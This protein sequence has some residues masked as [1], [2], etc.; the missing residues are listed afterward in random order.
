MQLYTDDINYAADIFTLEK[1][2]R[3]ADIRHLLPDLQPLA[4]K[5]FTRTPLLISRATATGRWKHGFVVKESS[6]SHY[7]LLI[8]L[9]QSGTPLPDGIV[10]LAGSGRNFHGQRGRPWSALEGNIHLA[11][12]FS[13][14][15]GID[16]Y[17]IGFPIVSAV[18]IVEAIDRIA[19]LKGRADIKWVNDVLIDGAKVA[20]FLAYTSSIGDCVSD[21]V[22][23]IGLNVEASP[24]VLPDAFVPGAASL[25]DF[26]PCDKKPVLQ[27]LLERLNH[28]YKLLLQGRCP[29][30]LD[31][32]RGRS[33]IIGRKVRILSDPLEG[34][35]QWEEIAAGRVER[36]GDH[37][38]LF[39]DNSPAP[40]TKGRLILEE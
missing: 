22:L 28:N 8:E 39:L 32:Y 24:E 31:T 25:R 36:I 14:Q 17:Q 20:G 4:G 40:V 1:E 29:E 37:L 11:V 7:D 6:S 30:L 12:H 18:S 27:T 23:G 16:R 19:G 15:Q 26:V 35:S 2:W 38:E 34:E 5:L 9:S 13:P 33:L 3:E 10:C 21:A